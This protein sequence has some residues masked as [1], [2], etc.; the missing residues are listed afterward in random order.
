[1]PDGSSRES[2]EMREVVVGTGGRYYWMSD[3]DAIGGIV[4]A[5]Q[6]QEATVIE[7]AARSLR[8][9]N[10]ALPV[11]AAS[12]AFVVLVAASRRWRS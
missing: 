3:G 4:D 10:P 1:M 12:L 2:L 9:D 11:T 6:A 8:T 7:S 5:V